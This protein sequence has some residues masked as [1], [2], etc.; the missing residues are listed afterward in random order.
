M[1]TK[2]ILKQK[3][4]DHPKFDN[5]ERTVVVRNYRFE[6]DYEQMVLEAHIEHRFKDTGELAE[7]FKSNIKDWIVNNSTM[8][9]VRNSDGTKKENPDYDP[10]IMEEDKKY[11]KMPSYNYFHLIVTNESD[12]SLPLVTLLRS[13]IIFNDQEQF[14]DNKIE[15]I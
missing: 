5:I 13:H 8:T 2:P 7:E 15:L 3:I 14:F 9:T 4:S 11:V 12:N 6:T 10:A 1:N